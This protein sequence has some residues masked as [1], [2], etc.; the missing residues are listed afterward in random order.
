MNSWLKAFIVGSR[1]LLTVYCW[2]ITLTFHYN[3]SAGSWI[4]RLGP[5]E[6]ERCGG[7]VDER[8]EDKLH[9]CI[10]SNTTDTLDYTVAL[11]D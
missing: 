1:L 7:G 4:R 5:V 2:F 9:D 8:R 10:H 6:S 3:C 11:L